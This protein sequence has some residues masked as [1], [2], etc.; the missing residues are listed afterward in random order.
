MKTMESGGKMRRREFLESGAAAGAVLAAS[1]LLASAV[2]GSNGTPASSVKLEG[3]TAFAPATR[4]RPYKS[5]PVQAA[6]TPTWVQFD[7]GEAQPVEAVRLYPW[8]DIPGQKSVSKG[9][10]ARLK[11]E[12]SNAA[13]FAQ[14]ALLFDQ[15]QSDLPD[16]DDR[17]ML[18]E[19]AAPATKYRYVRL[20]ATVLRP[21]RDGGDH[22]LCLQKLDVLAGGRNVAERRPATCDAQC[23]NAAELDQLTRPA[24]PMGEGVVTNNPGNVTDPASWRPPR[25]LAHV[26]RSGVKLEGGLLRQAVDNNIGY[27]LASFSP[28]EMLRP[29]R[30]RAGK[31]VGE[32][33]RRQ[34]PFWD[35]ALGGSMA[36]RFLMGA[37]NTLR[38][39]EH[40]ELRRWLN[41]IVDGIADCRQP[42]GFIMGYPEQEIFVSERAGYTRAW[43]THGLIEAGIA[44]HPKAN[45]LL[46]GFY[47]WFDNFPRISELMRGT[48]QG[49]QGM[50]GNTRMYFT[51]Q[52]KPADIQLVQRYYQENYWLD[53]LARRDQ[54]MVWQYPY[55]RPHNYLLTDIEAYMD[56]YRATG[57]ARYRDAVL[58]AWDLYHDNWEH[59]G[60][61]IAITEFGEFPPKSYR[62][63]AQFDFC[64]TGELCG[65]SFWSFLSQRLMVL[66]PENERY[67]NEIEKSI[68]N[69]GIANQVDWR[70]LMYHARLTGQ[71]G[72]VGVGYCDNSCCEGQGTRFIASIPEH[73]YSTADDGLYV[74]LFAPSSIEWK[75]GNQRL[76]LTAKTSFPYDTKVDLRLALDSQ[77]GTKLR[78]RTPSWAVAPMPV[79]VNGAVVATGRPG[80][81][82]TLDRT[83]RDGDTITFNLPAGLR[84]TRY[85]GLDQI[86]GASRY[87]LEY[88]P[89]L[90]AVPDDDQPRLRA[91]GGVDQFTRQ[92]KAVPGH[93]LAFDIEGNAGRR[94]VPYFG[95]K[96]QLFTCFP[97]IG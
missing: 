95:I 5:K 43:L 30:Q 58:G 57:E 88:G 22:A 91:T 55:D 2:P 83:W 71:K 68:Y 84:L 97:V 79:S 82:V 23:G 35:T 1:P 89:I 16:P 70:G 18:L 60:G 67:A 62:L 24:R 13:D 4:Y 6:A 61:S 40:A 19:L 21:T 75:Q 65:S 14:P 44:G 90:M 73:I 81:Y 54:N 59:V 63:K 48:S 11:V 42:N 49:N 33:M 92:L 38:W 15:T 69:I 20:T 34:S 36:G 8:F 28:D 9:F 47:D 50:V 31:P 27:L 94:F 87:A 77:C 3:R 53:G 37:G 29:F 17:M 56:L 52:G 10:P 45:E 96:N 51:P 41:T 80:T 46:R 39:Q 74:H 26:P 32:N 66:D 93:A 25:E 76:R 85:T 7:L 12:A 78:L 72:D 64:E 86:A